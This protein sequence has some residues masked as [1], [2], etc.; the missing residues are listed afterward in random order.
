MGWLRTSNS[1]ELVMFSTGNRIVAGGG[2]WA[3]SSDFVLT[4]LSVHQNQNMRS[5]PFPSHD[6]YL[7]YVQ[8]PQKVT[9]D[10]SAICIGIPIM[11][12][13]IS[14]KDLFFEKEMFSKLSINEMF[15]IMNKKL[16]TS[17]RK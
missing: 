8:E 15:D 5:L 1:N 13:D 4:K 11:S 16:K 2:D 10:M 9:I 17:R 3:I 12:T 6:G 14:A 7:Q